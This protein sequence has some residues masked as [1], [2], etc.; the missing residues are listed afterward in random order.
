MEM[1]PNSFSLAAGDFW[2]SA[3][4]FWGR[5]AWIAKIKPNANCDVNLIELLF[6]N[7]RLKGFGVCGARVYFIGVV[8]IRVIRV[9]SDLTSIS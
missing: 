8:S 9:A 2:P 5:K 6:D 3:W 4:G 7:Y 1:K